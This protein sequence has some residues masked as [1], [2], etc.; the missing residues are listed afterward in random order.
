MLELLECG[1]PC[2]VETRQWRKAKVIQQ[3]VYY[4]RNTSNDCY[5][6]QPCSVC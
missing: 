2:S 1:W 3:I 4:S 6:M 5:S